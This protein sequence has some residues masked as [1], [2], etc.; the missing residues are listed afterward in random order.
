MDDNENEIAIMET[1]TRTQRIGE[2]SDA[3]SDHE[4]DDN[5]SDLMGREASLDEISKLS[6]K[7]PRHSLKRRQLELIGAGVKQ[8]KEHCDNQAE[9]A[10][11]RLLEETK[12]RWIS[13]GMMKAEDAD[14]HTMKTSRKADTISLK[15]KEL[16]KKEH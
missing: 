15:R 1:P 14:L 6:E 4:E 12:A 16:P 7:Q 2:E 11:V 9:S 13:S 3:M 10:R 8:F 5:P